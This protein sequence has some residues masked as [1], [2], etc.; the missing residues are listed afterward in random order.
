MFSVLLTIIS[1]LIPHLELI[2]FALVHM[3]IVHQRIWNNFRHS[4]VLKATR[5]AMR[6]SQPY[7]RVVQGYSRDA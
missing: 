3:N 7:K 2:C 6:R 5:K 1:S 4:L